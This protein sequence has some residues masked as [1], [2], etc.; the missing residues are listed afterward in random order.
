MRQLQGQGWWPGTGVAVAA[1]QHSSSTAQREMEEIGL[2]LN[3]R[4]EHWD[5]G[6]GEA[7][8]EAARGH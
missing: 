1:A 6:V 7:P 3:G 4:L 2:S 5:K 8:G